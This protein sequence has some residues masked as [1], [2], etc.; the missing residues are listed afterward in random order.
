M[1]KVLIGLLVVVMVLSLTACSQE[2]AD[3]MGKM[4]NNVYGI[5]ADTSA[6]DEA[7]AAVD[8]STSITKDEETGAVT[9][10]VR[11]T[12]A[13]S[14]TSSISDIKNSPKK[15]EALKTQLAETVAS[16]EEEGAAV[17]TAISAAATAAAASIETAASSNAVVAELYNALTNVEASLSENPTKAELATVAILSEVASTVAEVATASEAPTEEQLNAYL[18]QGLA[19]YDTLVVV[20]EVANIDVIG[21][22]DVASLLSGLSKDVS[23]AE[24]DAFD[25]SIFKGT[26]EN[27]L[28]MITTDKKFDSKKY[29][30]FMLQASA[31]KKSMDLAVTKFVKEDPDDIVDPKNVS[32]IEMGLTID[33]LGLYLV[34]SIFV[35][36]RNLGGAAWDAFAKAYVDTNYDALAS[37]GKAAEFVD[38]DETIFYNAMKEIDKN[39]DGSLTATTKDT[40]LEELGNDMKS[41]LANKTDSRFTADVF[42]ILRTGAVI[43]VDAEYTGLL[44]LAS[45][46]GNISG[47]LSLIK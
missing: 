10:T 11:L 29:N 8:N 19:A 15:T 36:A 35:E 46:D 9:A 12:A 21:D 37:F 38:I 4:S 5:P 47:L 40:I 25:Y 42:N 13:A 30:L 20:S 33:D 27:I 28:K 34:T 2:L 22:I 17:K 7:T 6:A 31:I 43:L 32:G 26:V 1:K 18:E 14:I 23:R 3:L 16:T 45:K 44:K 41:A 24:D 39:V